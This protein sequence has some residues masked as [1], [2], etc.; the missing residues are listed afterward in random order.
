MRKCSFSSLSLS[1][2][3]SSLYLQP[4]RR[5]SPS[6]RPSSPTRGPS[7]AAPQMFA[8]VSSI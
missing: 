2:K 8:C 3:P 5:S 6:R 7:R 1:P 4:L